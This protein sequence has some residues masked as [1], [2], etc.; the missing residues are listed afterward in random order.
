MPD[1]EVEQLGTRGDAAEF[2]VTVRGGAGRPAAADGPAAFTIFIENSLLAGDWTGDC[3][4]S[5]AA[6]QIATQLVESVARGDELAG[7]RFVVDSRV[8]GTDLNFT[9]AEINSRGWQP[10]AESEQQ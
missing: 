1:V 7:Q 2:R 3:S 6:E 8:A 10:F 4:A 9:L 5:S